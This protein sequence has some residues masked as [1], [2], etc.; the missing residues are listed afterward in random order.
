MNKVK[1]ENLALAILSNIL[2]L[3]HQLLFYLKNTFHSWQNVFLAQRNYLNYLKIEEK[4]I[5]R[6]LYIKKHNILS[7][8]E[9]L[10][11]QENIE[12]LNY[13]DPL[14]PS[15]LRETKNFPLILFYQGSLHALPEMFISI[16]GS[17]DCSPDAKKRLDYLLNKLE[18]NYS[19]VSGLALGIDTYVHL[20][21]LNNNLHTCAILGSGLK[22]VYP[23]QNISLAKEIVY[24]QGCLISQFLPSQ[25]PLKYHFPLRN[26]II[27][28]MSKSTLVIE[29]KKRSG[30][31]ITANLALDYG[32][33]VAAVPG[34]ILLKQYEG[35]NELIKNGA[36][37]ITNQIDIKE[38]LL[39]SNY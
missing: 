12:L 19:L 37:V 7:K 25:K 18:T 2:P 13:Q 8:L 17:R 22:Q 16:V 38:S 11:A 26:Q 4:Y 28:G 5:D 39:D 24:N 30:A 10:L 29:A 34:N 1:S 36:I 14:F 21:A 35:S 27:A 31:L 9:N 3:N 23:K 20:A 33:Y 15:L 32:R 6:M